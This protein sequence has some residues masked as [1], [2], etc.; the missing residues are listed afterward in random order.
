MLLWPLCRPM[1]EGEWNEDFSRVRHWLTFRA[2]QRAAAFDQQG[3]G[4][5]WRFRESQPSRMSRNVIDNP[6]GIPTPGETWPTHSVD[7]TYIPELARLQAQ[8]KTPFL[9]DGRGAN[10]KC[11]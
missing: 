5:A 6:R 4:A 1:R 8:N 3:I 10:G 7:N 2:S 9:G 11:C